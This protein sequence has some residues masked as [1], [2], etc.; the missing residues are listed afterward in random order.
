[1]NP[2]KI[3]S[4]FPPCSQ[5]L[6]FRV[7]SYSNI[8]RECGIRVKTEGGIRNERIMEGRGMENTLAVAGLYIL[9]RGMR[10]NFKI[11][12]GLRVEQLKITG[13]GRRVGTRTR[14]N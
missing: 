6:T 7:Y 14:R 3:L 13:Y 12:G 5:Q 9:T 11:D 4:R 8:L 2:G 1:M 10:D